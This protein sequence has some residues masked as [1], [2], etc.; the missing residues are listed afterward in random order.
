MYY[1]NVNGLQTKKESIPIIVEKLQ[2]KIVALCET[3]LASG[4]LIEKLLPSYEVSTTPTK[5]G[6]NGLA[7][8]VKKQ[9]FASILDVTTTTSNRILVVRIVMKDVTIRVILGYSPQETGDEEDR[10]NFYTELAVEVTKCKM[11]EELPV[12]VGD[13]NAKI[14]NNSGPEAEQT[15]PNGKLLAQLVSDHDLEVLNFHNKCHGKWTHVIRTTGIFRT[16][17]HDCWPRNKQ[18]CEASHH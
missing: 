1:C 11:A 7:I 18:M 13:I 8:C 9:T 2:P 10:Q 17:L 5:A 15:S 16:R 4:N 6:Q 12:L 14:I 3:K